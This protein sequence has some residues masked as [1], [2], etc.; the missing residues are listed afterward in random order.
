MRFGLFCSAQADANE[1]GP[2]TGQG[3]RDYLDFN[4]EAEAPG[5]HSTCSLLHHHGRV[6]TLEDIARAPRTAQQRHPPIWVAAAS[7]L[8]IR[9]AA[10]R[11]FNLILDQYAAPDV[12]GERIALYRAA[13][14][15]GGYALDPMQM[16]V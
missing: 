7:P 8:S 15:A 10:A 1:L 9:R 6:G 3:F 14:E 13:R 4:V 5:H 11:G 16:A 12:I 2:E